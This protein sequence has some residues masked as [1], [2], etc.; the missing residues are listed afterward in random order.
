V[1]A[2]PGDGTAATAGCGHLRASRA[3]REHVLGMLKAAFVQG[4]LTKDEL[5]I[6]LGQ[7]FAS[8]T[9]AE[10]AALTADI[11]AGQIGAQPP[12][13]PAR[14]HARPP[15][16]AIIQPGAC[17]VIGAILV[18]IFFFGNFGLY[19]AV[20][21]AILAALLLTSLLILDPWLKK[22]S[23]GQQR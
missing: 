6:R 17:G 13:K 1:A 5:D 21:V 7:T 22:R 10:L 20:V 18:A 8:R 15:M 14:A 23:S 2:G 3:D 9:Y 19:F 11:S 4:Q 12:W 16:N